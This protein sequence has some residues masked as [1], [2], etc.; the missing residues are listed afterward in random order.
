VYNNFYLDLKKALTLFHPFWNGSEPKWF[1]DQK[2]PVYFWLIPIMALLGAYFQR[3]N[4]KIIFW[5]FVALLAVFFSKQDALPI[6]N[7]YI[8][9][10][11][12]FPGFNAYREASKFYFVTALSYSILIGAFVAHIFEYYAK[13][14]FLKY[15]VYFFASLVFLWNVKPILT[16]EM[17]SIFTPRE[18]P[19]DELI[20]RNYISLQ[21]G[22]FRTLWN[23]KDSK[24]ASYS[25]YRPKL[26]TLETRKSQW[27]S[28][29]DYDN[30]QGGELSEGEA[31][32]L[33][34]SE[35]FA[36]QLLSE[37]SVRYL[38]S[39]KESFF[40]IEELVS[41]SGW[42]KIDLDLSRNFIFENKKVRPRIYFTDEIETIHQNLDFQNVEYSLKN[43]SRWN[44]TLKNLEGPI[45]VNFSEK[46]HPDWQIVCGDTPWYALI[47]KRSILPIGNHHA[48]DA[49][50]NA[51]F[52]EPD[53]LR[54][55]CKIDSGG[56]INLSLYYRPQ[57][58]L[59]LGGIIS[60]SAIFL[61]LFTLVFWKE[62][63]HN[64]NIIQKEKDAK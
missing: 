16:G 59:Y 62:K 17:H 25:T 50:L 32:K 22:S 5:F 64:R 26:D 40:M 21:N 10:H 39:N 24:W 52:L 45:W 58:F 43:S 55:I 2:T 9:M 20:I 53:E 57:T 38:I 18:I 29:K 15:S 46:Y 11:Q 48:T 61:S 60:L 56:N 49:G 37:S 54:K 1:D 4:R 41:N 8:W 31:N 12:N 3:K 7:A 35:N 23:P 13:K 42:K 44:F 33:F 6:K 27:K 34:F 51:F 36:P 19:T 63:G 30:L 28:I 47:R 14:K